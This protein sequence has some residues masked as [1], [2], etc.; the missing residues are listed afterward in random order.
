MTTIQDLGRTGYRE[1]GVP[2]SGAF[3]LGAH[4][5]ANALI[6][7]PAESAT[8]EMTLFGGAY[9]GTAAPTISVRPNANAD[10][11]SLTNSRVGRDC[12]HRQ[13]VRLGSNRSAGV[14]V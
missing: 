8:L 1:W 11:N 14:P 7:N 4:A 3:D 12:Q 5:L 6:G 2:V 13:L 9:R 10:G